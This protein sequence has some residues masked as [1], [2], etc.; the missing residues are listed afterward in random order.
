MTKHQGPVDDGA[1]RTAACHAFSSF[2]TPISFGL[3]SATIRSFTSLWRVSN[4]MKPWQRVAIIG[5][6]LIGGSIGIDLLRRGLAKEVVGIGRRPATMRT[7]KR[8]GACTSTTLDIAAGV[9]DADL[10][11]VCTPVGRIVEDVIS[12]ANAAR[13]GA[14]ITDAGS[15]KG[16]IVAAIEKAQQQN[17]LPAKVTFV[18]SHP[19]AGSEKSGPEAAQA[20][21]FVNRTVIVTPGESTPIG[22]VRTVSRLWRSLGAKIVTLTPL[23]H[24]QAVATISH[25]PHVVAAALAG[26]TED[27]TRRLVAG[28]W[29]DTTRIAG[30]DPVLWRQILLD[31]RTAVLASLDRYQLAIDAYRQALKRGDQVRLES[32]LMEAKRSRDALGS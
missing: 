25:L 13:P 30:G 10:I 1:L 3:R 15:T 20:D 26:I 27:D 7:A 24:D 8:V 4:L 19:M 2:L 32:L 9:A 18:G 11:V 22:A 29:Q 31:N 5:V 6:G 14:I 23:A 28:G 17:K 12:A 16:S 21:L